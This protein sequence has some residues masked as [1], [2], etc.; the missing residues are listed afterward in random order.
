M[1][2]YHQFKTHASRKF[3]IENTILYKQFSNLNNLR[4][5]ILLYFYY[6]EISVAILYQLLYILNM[7]YFCIFYVLNKILKILQILIVSQ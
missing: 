4:G 5:I 7:L 1:A 2:R 6:C 3:N